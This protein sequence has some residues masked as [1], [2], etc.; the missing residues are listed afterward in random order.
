MKK[1]YLI[2]FLVTIMLAFTGCT[3]KSL[4]L[5]TIVCGSYAVPGMFCYD[6]KGNEY[7]CS[8]IET[9]SFGR[10]L[11]TYSGYNIISDKYETVSVICQKY[12]SENV[13]YYEDICYAYTN[14]EEEIYELKKDND[15]DKEHQNDKMTKRSNE[16]TFDLCISI[17]GKLDY[18]KVMS[19]CCVHFGIN[20]SAVE[21]LV[22]IDS[23]NEDSEMYYLY[24]SAQKH[25]MIVD[26]NYDIISFEVHENDVL[27]DKVIKLKLDTLWYS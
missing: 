22:L 25:C 21:E 10:V 18:E 16:V 17:D 19:K 24:A 4:D 6:L 12:D 26:K 8:I 13:Y 5:E 3:D 14:S 11:F 9:D 2:I 27:K 23:G 1:K 7:E 15:W 20:E